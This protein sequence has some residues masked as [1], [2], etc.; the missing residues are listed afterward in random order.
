MRA[1]IIISLSGIILLTVLSAV[2]VLCQ[3]N[4][5]EEQGLK[6][7]D[8]LTGSDIDSV[9]VTNG[10][11]VLHIPLASFPQRGALDLSF[12]LRYSTHQ[13][14]VSQSCEVT[15]DNGEKACTESWHPSDGGLVGAAPASSMDW[16]LS[17]AGGGKN[18]YMRT[19]QS[20]DGNSHLL[21][22]FDASIYFPNT[23]PFPIYPSYALDG[24]ALKL[25]DSNTV[26]FPNGT[27]LSY[28]SPSTTTTYPQP[29]SITERMA[30]GSR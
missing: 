1:K 15:G 19:V 9:S 22:G 8:S 3:S 23:P 11:L 20:P 12:F 24:T 13:W 6:P 21:S 17:P 25:Q 5:N 26:V 7:Y 4:V 10:G 14:S 2:S 28:A 29:Q 16:R 30:I 27:L 18:N